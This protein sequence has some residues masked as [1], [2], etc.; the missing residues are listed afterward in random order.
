MK[1]RR[2]KITGIG[3]VTPAGIGR[4]EFWKGIMEPVSRVRAFTKLDPGLGP[5][6]AAY[7]DRFNIGDYVDRITVPK[8]SARHT[9][10]A[11]AA[12]KL[13]LQDAGLTVTEFNNANAVVVTGS[14]LM[15]FD[16]IGRTIEG[17]STKGIRGA[18]SRTVY[19]TNAA[20]IPAAIVRVLGLTARTMSVQTS[21]CAG[22]DAIGHAVHMVARGDADIAICG[23]TEAPLFRCPLVELRATGLTPSTTESPRKLNRPFDLWRTTG[24]VSEGACMLVIEPYA[25][26]RPGYCHVEGYAYA[27]DV[28]EVL[29]SG[30][31]I[32]MKQALAD[33]GVRGESIDTINA[34]GPGH[35]RID[36]AECSALGQI[37]GARLTRLS[38]VSIKG[39]IGNPLGAAPA[40]QVATAAL[41]LR[42]ETLPPTVNWEFADPACPLNLSNRLRCMAHEYTLVNSHGLAGV[43]ASIVMRKC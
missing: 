42:C 14:S 26:V 30:L 11:I 38:A 17:V 36:A 23:G 5:F 10:F 27:S 15:D 41:S 12:A 33:A 7:L 25:S 34:W 22:M 13:A 16:G 43:N 31:A 2:V 4:E 24:V 39:A 21:C 9:L 8:G 29:C 37:F 35:T 20:V 19:T 32:A 6:V 3:P 18:V 28:G 1:R 40:I